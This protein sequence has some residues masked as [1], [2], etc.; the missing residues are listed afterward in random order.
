MCPP[1]RRCPRRPYSLASEFDRLLDNAVKTGTV[2]KDFKLGYEKFQPR[3]PQPTDKNFKKNKLSVIAH[4]LWCNRYYIC[5]RGD[6]IE[7]RCYKGTEWNGKTKRCEVPTT[8]RVA[9][10]V[11]ADFALDEKDEQK[12]DAELERTV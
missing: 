7:R 8:Q 6:A 11:M 9:D 1:N 10:C 2:V 4:P 12:Y 3:C 5:D